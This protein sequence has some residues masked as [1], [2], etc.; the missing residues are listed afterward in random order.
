[1]TSINRQSKIFKT[2]EELMLDDDCTHHGGICF[3]SKNVAKMYYV[4]FS[5]KRTP[6]RGHYMDQKF[7]SFNLSKYI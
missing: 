1:M 3:Q 4:F 6:V 7:Y 5:K 2:N